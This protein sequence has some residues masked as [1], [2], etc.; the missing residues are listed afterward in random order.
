MSGLAK[1]VQIVLP[2]GKVKAKGSSQ[3]DT[4]RADQKGKVLT[5]PT[6]TEFREDLFTNRTVNDSRD[7]IESLLIDD[8]DMS[9]ALNAYLTVAN[10]SMI[11][12]VRDE[13]G[14]IDRDGYKTLNLLLAG[15]EQRSDYTT[16]FELARSLRGV[17]AD[18]RYMLLKRGAISTELIY[19]KNLIPQTFRIVD[20]KSIEWIEKEPGSYKPQQKVEGSDKPIKLDIPTFFTTFY[21]KDPN[22]IYSHSPFVSAINTI[23]A[24]Q[25][26]INDLYRIMQLTGFPRMEIVIMEE[27]LLKNAP[28]NVKQDKEELRQWTNDRISEINN[29]VTNIRPDQTLTHTDAIEVKMVNEKQP[30][31]AVDISKVIDVLNAQNQAGLKTMAVIIG[32]GESGQNTSSTEA[33]IFSMNAQELNEPIAILL[34]QAFSLMLR[35][36]GS[37]STVEVKFAPVELR[38]DLELEPQ[39][40]MKGARLKEDLSLGII[41]DDEYHLE[42]HGRLRPDEA[43][44]LSG[45]GFMQAS[46]A[47][48]NAEGVTPNDDPLGRSIASPDSKSAKSNT[49]KKAK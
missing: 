31:A 49:V 2:K 18:F 22:R 17:C 20:P 16:G 29:A 24:R 34:S 43:P 30:G 5:Q 25:Q 35:L 32:R 37:S 44:E 26:V 38:P 8:P 9:A 33:R 4:Y 14:I 39:R 46:S 48:V 27:I 10:T 7:L 42:M 12:K 1:A 47:S 21:R 6:Y 19:D 13:N 15:M 23:A 40:T 45:T 36:T 3:T 28:E 11:I 41:S